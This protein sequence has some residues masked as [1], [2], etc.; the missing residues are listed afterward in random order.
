LG[1]VGYA[2][3]GGEGDDTASLIAPGESTEDGFFGG[4]A[5][6]PERVIASTGNTAPAPAIA[7]AA[8][9]TQGNSGGGTSSESKAGAPGSAPAPGG[10]PNIQASG[11]DRKIVQTASIQLQVKEVSGG[12]EEVGRI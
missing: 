3:G 1:G 6:L 11:I 8:D 12:F 10:V 4:D 5:D 9:V 7:P 2:V